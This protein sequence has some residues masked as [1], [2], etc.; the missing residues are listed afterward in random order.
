MQQ[1]HDQL[2]FMHDFV[3]GDFG[4][5]TG[6]HERFEAGHDEFGRAAAQHGLLPEQV[7]FRLL[8]ER[9]LDDT[10]AGATDAGRISE[11]QLEGIAGCILVHGDEAGNA[12]TFFILTPYQAP[13]A[14]GSDQHD[15]EI[16]ARFNL[17]EVDGKTV[18]EK[19]GRTLGDVV[20]DSAVKALLHHVGREKR[21]D[22]GILHGFSRF[23]HREPVGFR[24]R[25]AGAI[26][27]QTHDY[28]E[29]AV[30]EIQ[31]VST[32]LAAIAQYRYLPIGQARGVDI[33][34]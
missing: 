9:R 8:G 15:I 29:S 22:C 13:G 11:C 31:C 26:P 21:N 1:V 32:P 6:F 7:G 14:L 12:V 20:D 19:Q 10:G 24:L 16:A 34:F 3:V 4:L 30:L 33:R 18:C 28:I 23:H 27:P 2:Q 17:L 25:P 5:V